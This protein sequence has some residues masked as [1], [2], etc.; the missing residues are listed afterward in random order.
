MT[1][2]ESNPLATDRRIRFMLLA[3]ILIVTTLP[4][5][6]AF[7]LLDRALTTSLNLGFNEQ[8][9]RALDDESRN[10][11][12]LRDLDGA[13]RDLY[14]AQFDRVEDLRH[15]YSNPGLVKR[16]VLESLRIYFALGMVGAVLLAVIAAALLS[17]SIARSYSTAFRE[18]LDKRE[19]V[20]YL[21]EMAS[22]QEL[23][24]MLAHE[25]KNPLT[26]IELLVTSLRRSFLTQSPEQFAVHLGETE[27]MVKEELRHLEKTVGKFS[28]FAKLPSVQLAPENL[29]QVLAQHLQALAGTFETMR[30][31]IDGPDN[32]RA[33]LDSTLFRQVLANIVRN[34]VEANPD[35]VV[36]FAIVLRMESDALRLTI[37]ND[38]VPVPAQIA[39][40]MFDPYVSGRGGKDNMGLGLAIVRKIVIEHN[41]EI[42][43]EVREGQ[44]TFVIT[45]PGT[46]L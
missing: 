39:A 21:Q 37:G 24:R 45:L 38:G 25:I 35:K 41:G 43:Y 32:V 13:N 46:V 33:M 29:S 9:L 18:L 22:W 23:A 16:S 1:V 6:A 20:E 44:P 12:R 31:R 11:R 2:R 10:L 28:A 26:P 15:V 4:L 34:G 17:R 14:R 5:I 8:I 27:A 30:Y 7:Y 40:R 42:H 3:A 19:R 36:S